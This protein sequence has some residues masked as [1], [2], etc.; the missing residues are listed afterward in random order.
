MHEE[1]AESR[2][3]LPTLAVLKRPSLLFDPIVN[4]PACFSHGTHAE[5]QGWGDRKAR[6]LQLPRLPRFRLWH[7]SASATD[8]SRRVRQFKFEWNYRRVRYGAGPRNQPS[9]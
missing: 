6:E 9:Y 7:T 2:R 3:H 1:P 8:L 4:Q 5:L